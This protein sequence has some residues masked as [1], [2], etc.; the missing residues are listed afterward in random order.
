MDNT[1]TTPDVISQLRRIRE[2]VG[3]QNTGIGES[4]VRIEC[5]EQGFGEV[6]H[7][8]IGMNRAPA[9]GLRSPSWRLLMRGHIMSQT[10]ELISLWNSLIIKHSRCLQ[11]VNPSCNL[12]P[13]KQPC[14]ENDSFSICTGACAR[15]IRFNSVHKRL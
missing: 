13:Q 2:H 12:I 5:S 8:P 14:A 4:A 6:E 1:L 7:D 10:L 9:R 11:I 3:N 15:E